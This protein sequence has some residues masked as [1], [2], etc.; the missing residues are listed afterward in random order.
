MQLFE[1]RHLEGCAMWECVYL[2]TFRERGSEP[3]S[4]HSPSHSA[5][6][7]LHVGEDQRQEEKLETVVGEQGSGG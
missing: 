2:V 5:N 4:M 6:V 1:K 3:R 7:G